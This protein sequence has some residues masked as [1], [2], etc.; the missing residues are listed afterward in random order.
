MGYRAP[1]PPLLEQVEYVRFEY[2]LEFDSCFDLPPFGLLQL[3]REFMQ[4]LKGIVARDVKARLRRLFDPELSSDPVVLRQVQKPAPP[5][6][7]SPDVSRS[8]LIESGQR[9][10]LPVVFVG[11][12]VAAVNDFSRLVRQLE[13]QG[14]Y[15]GSGTF[16]LVEISSV[17]GSGTKSPVWSAGQALD[18]LTFSVNCLGWWL[19][20]QPSVATSI[21]LEILSP[22]R[23]FSHRKPLFKACFQQLFPH[24]LRRVSALVSAHC[25]IDIIDSPTWF[26]NLSRDVDD[27]GTFLRWKDWRQLKSPVR[28]QNL[29]GLVG[30]LTLSGAA[31]DELWWILALG[32]F[33]QVGKGASYGAG[34]YHLSYS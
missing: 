23:V 30:R 2:C 25:A 32:H 12:G 31:L 34:Q 10:V 1:F 5:I 27:N 16:R 4:A 28:E 8:G 18:Q 19:E 9:I 14:I 15:R 3:R 17:D 22:I 21:E 7:L 33:F 11:T 20:Q 24:I 29:G 13:R 6:V 26:L